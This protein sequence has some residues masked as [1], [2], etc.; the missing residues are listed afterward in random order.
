MAA[1]RELLQFMSI[2]A[3]VTE[4][5]PSQ[6]SF[7]EVRID[8]YLLAYQTT[9]KPPQPCPQEPVSTQERAARGLPPLFEPVSTSSVPP[10]SENDIPEWHQFSE[11]KSPIAPGSSTMDRLQSITAAEPY[12]SFSFEQLRF[13]AY[14]AGRIDPPP[15]VL[16][17]QPTPTS[18]FS[19]S[20]LQS[21]GLE[22]GGNTNETFLSISSKPEFISHSFEELR[23]A[24]MKAN[25][26]D[27]T[28]QEIFSVSGGGGVPTPASL[29]ESPFQ[30]PSSTGPGVGQSPAQGGPSIFGAPANP[31]STPSGS[32]NSSAPSFS[33][34]PAIRF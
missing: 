20:T 15:D 21:N 10:S 22:Y 34:S 31:F 32:S 27:V 23:V 29:L 19:S 30:A 7:E 12:V 5:G 26:R 17:A 18:S 13:Y 9:G 1:P 11:T 4:S 24:S 2:S 33:F 25:G 28:S 3:A 6:K 14:L 16:V 8:D